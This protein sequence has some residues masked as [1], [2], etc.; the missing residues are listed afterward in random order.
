METNKK[1]LIKM[2]C[3]ILA[4]FIITPSIAYTQYQQINQPEYWALIIS[5]GIYKGYP[6][7]EIP[8]AIPLAFTF[9]EILNH[10]SLWKD[11]HIK[12]ITGKNATILNIIRGFLWLDAHEDSSDIALVYI[13]T[14]GAQLSI[15]KTPN[16]EIPIDLPPFDEQD[17]KDEILITYHGFQYYPLAT[18][19]DDMLVR[20]IDRLESHVRCIIINSCYAG[21]FNEIIHQN[22]S[23]NKTILMMSCQENEKSYACSFPTYLI[24]GLQGPADTNYDSICTAEE[25]FTYARQ[26]VEQLIPEQHPIIIDTFP[27]ELALV[28][29][30]K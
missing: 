16:S 9:K 25:A 22:D 13:H 5:V 20:F 2:I 23:V 29:N 11:D 10:T 21:G 4:P 17:G 24:E 12:I 7:K 27:G 3:F 19:R 14:H 15:D 6:D 26:K 30:P 28:Y 8:K 1:L 18:I